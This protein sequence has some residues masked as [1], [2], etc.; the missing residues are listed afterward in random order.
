MPSN[1]TLP[2][3][4]G[5]FL[6]HGTHG[7]MQVAGETPDWHKDTDTADIIY[8]YQQAHKRPTGTVT[9]KIS[10]INLRLLSIHVIMDKKKNGLYI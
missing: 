3:A 10:S 2:S 7:R 1:V 4:E 8:G 9:I 6:K 5:A